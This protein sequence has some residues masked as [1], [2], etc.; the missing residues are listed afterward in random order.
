MPP[1]AAHARIRMREA[2]R[3]ALAMAIALTVDEVSD[4]PFPF[5]TA[6]F[7]VQ[8]LVKSPAAPGL[9]QGIGFAA[10]IGRSAYVALSLC[11]LL[12]NRPVAYLIVLAVGF[13]ICFYLQGRGKGG[14]LPQLLLI[15][16]AALPVMAVQSADLATDFA[17]IMIEA[18]I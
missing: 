18:A 17:N 16:N 15:C 14:P 3:I 2:L 4:Q 10:V 1:D 11:G 12:I 8:M 5:L 9:K 7:A 6:L 13:F